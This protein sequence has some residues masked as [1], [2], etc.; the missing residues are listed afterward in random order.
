MKNSKLFTLQ[1]IRLPRFLTRWRGTSFFLAMVFI[2]ATVFVLLYSPLNP[3]PSW[4]RQLYTTLL[5]GSG[6]VVLLLSR[7][8][9]HLVHRH[10]VLYLWQYVAWG[11]AEVL[12]FI[13]GL[14]LFAYLLGNGE[15]FPALL[16][17]VALDVLGILLVPYVIT[18]LLFML[19]EKKEEI[20]RLKG[21]IDTQSQELASFKSG[22]AAFPVLNFYD[23][24]GRL[25]IAMRSNDVLYIESADN[26][27]IIHYVVDG[28]EE[29]FVL[30]NSMKYFDSWGEETGLLRCHRSYIVNKRNVK[31]LRKEKDSLTLELSQGV[32]ALP[33]SRS[34]RPTVLQAF[35]PTTP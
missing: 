18:V 17:R 31:L 24:G 34:Y 3:P 4:S 28:K 23:R 11:M 27:C 33:V 10:H 22:N 7:V 16:L 35:T 2:I 6:F 14:A 32:G 13:F 15:T 20:E 25:A 19:D 26:Y 30:H 5:V 12:V 29:T 8:I 1:G 9:L 21:I